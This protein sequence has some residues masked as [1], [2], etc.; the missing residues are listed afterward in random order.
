MNNKQRLIQ[1]TLH[2]PRT[3][4]SVGLHLGRRR[5]HLEG[6][7]AERVLDA[8]AKAHGPLVGLAVLAQPRREQ[9]KA[10]GAAAVIT[11]VNE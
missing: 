10:C 8:H 5:L 6:P 7:Q 11:S 1:H 4:G 3:C 2:A 9:A